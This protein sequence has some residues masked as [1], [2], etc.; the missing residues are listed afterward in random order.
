M[1]PEEIKAIRLRAGLSARGLAETLGLS[2]T[3]GRY[4]RMMETGERSASGPIV[5]MLEMLDRGELPERYIV[6]PRKRGP[7]PK[8]GG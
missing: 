5:R 4:V 2:G 3:D 7:K 8:D 6:R 1:M